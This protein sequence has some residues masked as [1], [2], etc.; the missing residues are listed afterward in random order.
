MTYHDAIQLFTN[1]YCPKGQTA[2]NF[3]FLLDNLVLDGVITE[4]QSDR[5]STQHETT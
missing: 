4:L 3:R 2:I 5:W 1:W